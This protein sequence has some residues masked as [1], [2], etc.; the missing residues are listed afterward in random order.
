M[1]FDVAINEGEMRRLEQA[2]SRLGAGLALDIHQHGAVAA[3]NVAAARARQLV[4]VDEGAVQASI[5]VTRARVRQ[6]RQSVIPG[7]YLVAGSTR[8]DRA[9]HAVLIEYGTVLAPAQPFIEPAILQTRGGQL[10]A[11][12]RGVLN[13]FAIVVR[14]LATGTAGSRITR[15]AGRG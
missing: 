9:A 7:A 12:T 15:L 2:M 11:Y 13:R 6:R 14:R 8:N 3:A 5:R 1:E 10:S 4:P